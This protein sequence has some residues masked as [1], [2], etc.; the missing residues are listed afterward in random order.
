MFLNRSL[1]ALFSEVLSK[2]KSIG[3][4]ISSLKMLA[5][6]DSCLLEIEQFLAVMI[7]AAV[8]ISAK[9]AYHTKI[10]WYWLLQSG[11]TRILQFHEFYFL[12]ENVTESGKVYI[13]QYLNVFTT[14]LH[15]NCSPKTVFQIPTEAAMM[16]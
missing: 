7:S 1:K 11:R 4:G 6:N 9:S 2:N 16:L 5:G 3:S 10:F 13:S 14:S 12:T 15:H 8:K